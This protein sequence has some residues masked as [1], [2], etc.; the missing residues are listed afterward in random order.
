M[1]EAIIELGVIVIWGT[2][3]WYHGRRL[4][5][6]AQ[7]ETDPTRPLR[8]HLQRVWWW[9][10]REEYWRAVQPDGLRCV[11]ATLMIFLMAWGVIS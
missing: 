9:L 3:L 1:A 7:I 6:L 5:R 4:A 11:Q 10:G 8:G 2:M